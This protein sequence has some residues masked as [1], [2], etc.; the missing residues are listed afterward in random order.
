V[1][2]Q[3]NGNSNTNAG[4]NANVATNSNENGDGVVNTGTDANQNTNALS[5]LNVN[6]RTTN[7]NN[8]SN[9]NAGA[10]TVYD[11]SAS[12]MMAFQNLDPSYKV[13]HPSNWVVDEELG[14]LFLSANGRANLE[15]SIGIWW[16]NK[17]LTGN[18]VEQC[19]KYHGWGSPDGPIPSNVKYDDQRSLTVDGKGAVL[20]SYHL[21]SDN[22]GNTADETIVCIPTAHKTM[23]VG[24][25]PRLSSFVTDNFDAVL[26]TIDIA[27]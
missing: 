4:Q 5:N 19:K 26:A 11:S 27:E 24:A 1:Y 13:S 6:K 22:L 3:D 9:V 15:P 14:G 21:E 12:T 20:V 18:L 10:W 2:Q 23:I 8:N 17:S 16:V 25:K 7:I